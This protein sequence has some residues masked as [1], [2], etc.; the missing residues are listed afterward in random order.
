MVKKKGVVL[1]NL[2]ICCSLQYRLIS[3]RC[4][5]NLEVCNSSRSLKYLFIYCLK[6][7]D[8]ATMILR[9]KKQSSIESTSG[10][11][12]KN[13]DEIQNYLDG[14]YVCAI[15]TAWRLFGFDIHYRYPSIERFPVYMEGEINVTFKNNDN[16]V[17]VDEKA[18][19]KNSKLEG[20]FAANKTYR[21]VKNYTYSDVG[22]WKIR[23]RCTVF[24]RLSN[25]HASA[26]EKFFLRMILMQNK[27]EHYIDI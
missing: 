25:V 13:T 7:H 4:H 15:E 1:D 27:G 11:K 18:T 3:L 12:G 2:Y 22:K 19:T 14:R 21:V 5:I 8:T 17:E 9:K 10:E 20:W 24:G 16:W 6:G 23:E 26:G